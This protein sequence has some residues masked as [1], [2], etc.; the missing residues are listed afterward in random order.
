MRNKTVQNAN[1][2]MMSGMKGMQE[3]WRRDW[4]NRSIPK[5]WNF[6]DERYPVQPKKMKLTVTLDADMVAWFRKLGRGYQAQMNAILRIY[7]KGLVSGNVKSH[8]QE[9]RVG[10]HFTRH[11]LELNKRILADAEEYLAAGLIEPELLDE[12]RENMK[13]QARYMYRSQRE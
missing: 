3:R 5:D 9:G 12:M 2:D 4:V 8:W 11:N 1:I 10:A 6:L 13:E 7:W